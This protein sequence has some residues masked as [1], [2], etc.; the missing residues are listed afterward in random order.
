[1]NLINTIRMNGKHKKFKLLVLILLSI[2]LSGCTK[3]DD[4]ANNTSMNQTPI[5]T[6]TPIPFLT[7]PRTV[8]VEI[9]GSAFNPLEL[10]IVNGTT[11]QWINKDSS[12]HIIYINNISSPALNKRDRWNYTFDRQGTFEYNCTVQQWI[13]HGR[14]IVR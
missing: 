5:P 14:I 4:P 8:Y 12:Q 13:P 7:E 9:F 6:G 11:V 1:M 2:A 3:F 10:N